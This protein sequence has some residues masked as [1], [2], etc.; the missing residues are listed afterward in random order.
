MCSDFEDSNNHE[1]K[2]FPFFG[3]L[4]DRPRIQRGDMS[5]IILRVLLKEPMHGYQIIRTLEEKSHGFWRPSAGSVYPTLQLLTEQGLIRGT[6]IDGKIVY[7]LTKAGE[8]AAKDTEDRHPWKAHRKLRGQFHTFVPAIKAMFGALKQ[9]SQ[10]D[11]DDK[12]A[13]AKQIL[14]TAASQLVSLID[15]QSETVHKE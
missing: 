11:D 6:D 10:L 1:Q 13:K 7:A 2:F 3:G 4:F 5:P 9:V 12:S 8:V 14:D 15:T